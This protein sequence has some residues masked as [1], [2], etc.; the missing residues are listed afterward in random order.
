MLHKMNLWNSPFVCIKNG[1]KDIE[2]RLNDEKRQAVSEGDVIEFT[3]VDTGE[4]LWVQVLEKTEYKDF[5]ELYPNYEKSRMGYREDE[6][7]HPHDMEKYYPREKIEKYG[8]V[9]IRI[10]LLPNGDGNE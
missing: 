8:V 6:A 7:C 5:H 10:T 1:T 4:C 9:A 3:N 2:L